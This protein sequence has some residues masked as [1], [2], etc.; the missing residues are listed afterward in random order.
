M[1][2]LEYFP[3]PAK[4]SGPFAYKWGVVRPLRPPG[5]GPGLSGDF[6][7]V[8]YYVVE[9]CTVNM[10]TYIYICVQVLVSLGFGIV[11]GFVSNA[12]FYLFVL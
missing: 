7:T 3:S 4:L 9:L 12:D 8:L 5:Y 10:C 1:P 6:C 2:Q 11:L